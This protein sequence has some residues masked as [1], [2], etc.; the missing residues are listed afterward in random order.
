[1]KKILFSAAL[2]MGAA[3]SFA[4]TPKG[5]NKDAAKAQPTEVATATETKT[6]QKAQQLY[7]YTPDGANSLGYGENPNNGCSQPGVGCAIGFLN[8]DADPG[9]DAPDQTRKED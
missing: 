6:E 9:V 2:L 8:E 1:M 3:V 7:W 5:E 4:G